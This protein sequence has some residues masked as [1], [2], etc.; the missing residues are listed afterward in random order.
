MT[1]KIQ[2]YEEAIL[3]EIKNNKERASLLSKEDALYAQYNKKCAEKINNFLFSIGSKKSYDPS[4]NS[5]I[6]YFIVDNLEE[7]SE[8][9]SKV[10]EFF[11][12]RT[13]KILKAESKFQIPF[14]FQATKC[15]QN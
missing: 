3:E 4:K 5:C 1:T 10:I 9:Q 14:F 8:E 15:L 7:G 2:K 11:A 6:E 13:L 12:R